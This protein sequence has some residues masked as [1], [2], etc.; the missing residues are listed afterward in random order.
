MVFGEHLG[1]GRYQASGK[2]SD[3]P[4]PMGVLMEK[5][6]IKMGTTKLSVSGA[7]IQIWSDMIIAQVSSWISQFHHNSLSWNLRPL[8]D[9]F[10]SK[11]H[12]FLLDSAG[13]QANVPFFFRIMPRPTQDPQH[14]TTIIYKN[15]YKQIFLG[16][17]LQLRKTVSTTWHGVRFSDVPWTIDTPWYP[18][19]N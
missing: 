17:N 2:L 1:P 7:N 9:D 8:G 14:P 3:D 19:V 16:G 5:M 4:W 11:K 6:L 10:P 12:P 13:C 18:L 15:V